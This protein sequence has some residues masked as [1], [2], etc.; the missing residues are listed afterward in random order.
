MVLYFQGA[1]TWKNVI[2]KYV[3]FIFFLVRLAEFSGFL[4]ALVNPGTGMGGQAVP[5]LVPMDIVAVT[6]T[7]GW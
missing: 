7:F 2:I 4:D 5:S 1:Y 3:S 6:T